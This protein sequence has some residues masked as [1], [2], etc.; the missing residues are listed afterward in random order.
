MEIEFLLVLL[1]SDWLDS[2][3]K[4]NMENNQEIIKTELTD[5]ELLSK[6]KLV[7]LSI[8][9]FGLYE[10]WWIYKSWRFLK[11]KDNLDIMPAGRA[12]FSLF[13][14]ISL[15]ERIK[16]YSKSIGYDK[17]FSSVGFYIAFIGLNFA[18]R[19]PDPYW[20]VSFLSIFFLVPALESMNFGIK[21]SGDYIV[22]E[23]GKF[24][25]RQ[26]GLVIIGSILWL[27]MLIGLF[28]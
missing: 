25:N 13:T 28:L 8:L 9:S 27:L 1:V 5:F 20:M 18:G 24:N 12:I 23:N 7:L 4:K 15:F 6:K 21:N 10:L 19:L 2:D 26:K 17:P 3:N 14:L 11:Y 22:N 16:S